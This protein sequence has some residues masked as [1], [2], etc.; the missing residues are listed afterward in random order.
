MEKKNVAQDTK[1]AD[2]KELMA[3][4]GKKLIKQNTNNKKLSM[5]SEETK[6]LNNF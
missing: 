4:M 3:K 1:I 6:F 5:P 2:L